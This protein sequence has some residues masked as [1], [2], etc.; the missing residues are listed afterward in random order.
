MFTST[1]RKDDVS[2]TYCAETLT[3]PV[4]HEDHAKNVFM[5]FVNGNRLPQLI[6]TSNKEGLTREKK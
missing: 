1:H 5:G 6:P 2:V 4:I 3:T